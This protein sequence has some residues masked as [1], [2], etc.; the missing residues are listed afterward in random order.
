MD[1]EKTHRNSRY[2]N[3]LYLFNNEL[4]MYDNAA[5]CEE[6]IHRRQKDTIYIVINGET[7]EKE[8][9]SKI[10]PVEQIAS[11]Y[12]C[13][14]DMKTGLKSVINSTKVTSGDIF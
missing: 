4:E 11:I 6:E 14:G 2:E 8:F 12:I 7:E 1:K 5:A 3:D 10:E 9:I 13:S